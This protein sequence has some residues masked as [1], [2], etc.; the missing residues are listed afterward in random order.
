MKTKNSKKGPVLKFTGRVK[1]LAL[2]DDALVASNPRPPRGKSCAK[3]GSPGYE[4]MSEIEYLGTRAAA[5]LGLAPGAYL[6]LCVQKGSTEGPYLPVRTSTEAYEA[7][8]SH[9]ACVKK[10]GG[11][12]QARRS[13]AKKPMR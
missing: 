12:A 7:G 6:H 1:T 9:C 11:G 3:L 2:T 10:G 8:R 4:C 13:C 5:K